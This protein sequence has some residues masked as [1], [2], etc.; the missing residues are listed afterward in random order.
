MDDDALVVRSTTI[1]ASLSPLREPSLGSRVCL[2]FLVSFD[3]EVLDCEVS[4]T[5]MIEML[6]LLV[7]L[8]VMSALER[9]GFDWGSKEEDIPEDI[10]IDI[11][12]DEYGKAN[13]EEDPKN[14]NDF[15]SPSI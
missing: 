4:S 12:D 13:D 15:T 1:L 2:R 7:R 8:L 6:L 10:D 11:D 3:D 14:V 5:W 9:E